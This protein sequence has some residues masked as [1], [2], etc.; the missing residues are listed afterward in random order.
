MKRFISSALALGMLLAPMGSLAEF[1]KPSE[2]FVLMTKG[3]LPVGFSGEL[4][5]NVDNMWFSAWI[6][7]SS[8]GTDVA[9][10]MGTV[11]G[12]FDISKDGGKARVKFQARMVDSN[13]YFYVDSI[14]GTYDDNVWH[15]ALS[16]STK[17]W[18]K[19]P[20]PADAAT[21]ISEADFSELDEMLQLTTRALTNGTEYDITLTRDAARN[22][23]KNL[24]DM[25]HPEWD[26]AFSAVPRTAAFH[27]TVTTDTSD[28]F[29]QAAGTLE[30]G[31]K[32]VTANAKGSAWVLPSLTV[33]APTSSVSIEDWASPLMNMDNMFGMPS[34]HDDIWEEHSGSGWDTP[35]DDVEVNDE[36]MWPTTE[37]TIPEGDCRLDVDAVRHNECSSFERTPRRLP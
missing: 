1:T 20:V 34:S 16:M 7:G 12:T 22:M 18:V 28:A 37:N 13:V 32:K 9:S 27:M 30:M 35:S 15:S 21:D 19:V 6:S 36:D 11:K 23:L 3:N 8:K 17:T 33:T 24:R 5:G 25:D 26:D 31:S 4:H 10:A 2:L 29:T 14:E